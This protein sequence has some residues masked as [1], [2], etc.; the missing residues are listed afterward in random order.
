VVL[1]TE[2]D[3]AFD[4]IRDTLTTGDAVVAAYTAAAG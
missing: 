2:L 4:R 1:T 3:D